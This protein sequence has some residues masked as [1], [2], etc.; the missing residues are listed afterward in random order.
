[1][2]NRQ[3]TPLKQHGDNK[4]PVHNRG[5]D[6]SYAAHTGADGMQPMKPQEVSGNSSGSHGNSLRQPPAMQS[7]SGKQHR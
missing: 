5:H 1:M 7:R 6:R 3:S 4:E 2:S